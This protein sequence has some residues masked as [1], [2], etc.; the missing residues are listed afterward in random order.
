MEN[1][2]SMRA[3]KRNG[4]TRRTVL[5]GLASSA[6]LMSIRSSEASGDLGFVA[7]VRGSLNRTLGGQKEAL[8]VGTPLMDG[9]LVSTAADSAAELKLGGDTRIL[10]GPET[11]LFV[12][13]FI[14][15]QGG[16]LELASGQMIFDRPEG[17]PKIDVTVRT[18][19]GMIGVRGTKFFAGP[20]GD[21]FSVF[22]EHGKVEV[23]N[24]GVMRKL[25]KGQGLDIRQPQSAPR[26]LGRQSSME[27]LSRFAIPSLPEVWEEARI[28]QAYASIGIE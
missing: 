24:A 5:S 12:D 18:A 10:L 17:L 16:V 2:S 6:V 23:A 8:S 20:M 28:R 11:S 15:G 26:S 7:K 3:N 22:V 27:E 25:L 13:S 1:K 4:M 19:F 14:A 21:A 9:D